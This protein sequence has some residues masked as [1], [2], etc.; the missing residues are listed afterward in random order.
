[1]NIAVVCNRIPEREQ[2]RAGI[3][4]FGTQNGIAITLC[5]FR[6]GTDLLYGMQQ[7]HYDIAIIALPGTDGMETANSA[8]EFDKQ[9]SI[10]WISDDEGFGM[11][12]YRLSV[13]SFMTFPVTKEQV[14]CALMRCVPTYFTN[15][16]TAD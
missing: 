7:K 4:S 1:M 16:E 2:I 15:E 11:M 14:V 13:R 8:S 6:T 5:E 12:S 9:L 3:D 10:I